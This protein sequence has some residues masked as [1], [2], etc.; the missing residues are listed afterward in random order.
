MAAGGAVR[1]DAPVGEVTGA[2]LRRR[3]EA[4]G[5]MQKELAAAIAAATGRKQASVQAALSAFETGSSRSV[6]P[7]VMDAAVAALP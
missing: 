1:A 3:R 5:M 7:D 6:P 4:A 2:E